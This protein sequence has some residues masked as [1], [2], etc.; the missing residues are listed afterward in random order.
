M[1]P[2]VPKTPPYEHAAPDEALLRAAQERHL[3]AFTGLCRDQRRKLLGLA[4]GI[5]GVEHAADVVQESLIR[6]WG[7][8]HLYEEREEGGLTGWAYVITKNT[9]IN[10]FHKLKAESA[11]QDRRAS[12]DELNLTS[13]TRAWQ[14]EPELIANEGNDRVRDILGQIPADQA[15]AVY[16]IDILGL[17]AKETAARLGIAVVNTV[18]TRARRGRLKLRQLMATGKVALS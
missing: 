3:E 2:Q 14:P 6:A 8:L 1:L 13:R 11:R 10:T 17:T 12:A 7:R 9:A 4:I 15:E 5:V 18:E 16:H